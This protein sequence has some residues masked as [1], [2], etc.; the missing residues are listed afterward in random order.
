MLII[1][2]N[3]P[4]HT[5]IVLHLYCPVMPITTDFDNFWG[6]VWVCVF[7]ISILG[8]F[9]FFC[10]LATCFETHVEVL[11]QSYQ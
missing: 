3:F 2:S 1:V 9:V 4:N 7:G 6:F 8:F 10:L 5:F 11:F